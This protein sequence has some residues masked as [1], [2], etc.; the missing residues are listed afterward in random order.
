MID[1]FPYLHRIISISDIH[2]GALDPVYMY[3]NLQEQFVNRIAKVEF[4]I[5]AI[6]GDL[7]EGRY[8]S[9]NPIVSYALS[10][11]DNLVNL[12][13]MKQATLVLLE[14]TPGHDNGQFKLFYHYLADPTVDVRVVENPQFEWIQNM[15]VL[16]IPEKYG[17]SEDLYKQLL[18]GSGAYDMC[19]MHGTFRGSFKGSEISSLDNIKSPI[20]SISHFCNCLGPILMGHYHISGCYE[21][22]AYYH[23]STFRY[24]FG[25][26]QEKG[27][28]ATIYDQISRYHLTRLI[29]FISQKYI[30]ININDL[31]DEDPKKIIEYIKRYKETHGID[32]IRVQYNTVTDNINITKQYFRTNQNVVMQELDKKARTLKQIDQTLAEHNAQYGYIADP[33][34]DDYT[35]FVMYV[36]Q[37]EKSECITVEDLISIL[38]AKIQ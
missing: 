20:F 33:E 6:C 10:F 18:F 22:H 5:L 28:L 13:K 3:N 16:C 26:E 23:G 37:Q 32:F 31:I 17:L 14:G 15:R 34:L 2:F 21:S 36:N 8:M 29:P 4:D 27:F 30:T 12:C 9:N 35:K 1:R 11:I 38:E 24:Q 25:E 7:F 19:L